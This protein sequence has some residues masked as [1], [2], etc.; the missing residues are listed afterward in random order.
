MELWMSII[1]ISM[2]LSVLPQGYRVWRRKTSNDISITLWVIMIHGI[3]WWL[4][5]GIT[6]NSISIIITNCICLV[7][8]SIILIMIIKYRVTPI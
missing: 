4:Y 5:Y 2:A 3:I 7:L 1:G 6:I 8:D